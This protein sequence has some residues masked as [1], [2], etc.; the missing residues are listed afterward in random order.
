MIPA[1]LCS[2]LHKQPPV[3]KLKTFLPLAMENFSLCS[4]LC[5]S[6]SVFVSPLSSLPSPSPPRHSCQCLS[7]LHCVTPVSLILN[8]KYIPSP[9][10]ALR[11][12]SANKHQR[13]LSWVKTTARSCTYKAFVV[14]EKQNVLIVRRVTAFFFHRPWHILNK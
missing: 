2:A 10:T 13:N 4:S 11:S 12:Y 9:C 14:F 6:R 8:I 1:A 5:P 3:N 7:V